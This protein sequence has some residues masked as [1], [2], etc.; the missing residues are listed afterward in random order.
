MAIEWDDRA[1]VA[2]LNEVARQASNLRPLLSEIGDFL[3]ESTKQRFTDGVGPDGEKWK[4]NSDTTINLVWTDKNGNSR[5]PKGRDTPLFYG[6][7]LQESI[8]YS[9][10]E[11]E[12]QVGSSMEYAAMQQFGGTK[13]EFPH[14]LGNIPERPFLGVSDADE[15]M[16]LTTVDGFLFGYL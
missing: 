9:A 5:G 13:D 12:L 6:G 14:L 4:G 10:G 1:V 3:V 16:I 15:Q 7:F 2:K 8:S 11:N